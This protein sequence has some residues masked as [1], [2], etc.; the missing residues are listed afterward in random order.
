MNSKPTLVEIKHDLAALHSFWVVLYGSYVCGR[1][2]SR[3]DIDVAV[4]SRVSDPQ[5][6][7]K[8]WFQLLGKASEKYDLKLFELLPL[9]IKAS[10]M[11]NYLVLFGD[12]LEISEYFYHFRK[13]W[14][15]SKRRYYA[16]QFTSVQEKMRALSS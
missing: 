5:K 9:E 4:I 10:I 14:N 6:N 2:T 12:A 3:S 13:L 1:F 7:K 15:D 11:D 16:N 8:I